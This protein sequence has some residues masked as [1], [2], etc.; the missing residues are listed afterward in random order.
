ME[1]PAGIDDQ[2]W[3]WLDIPTKHKHFVKLMA[4]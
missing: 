1:S 2:K 3:V 4:E